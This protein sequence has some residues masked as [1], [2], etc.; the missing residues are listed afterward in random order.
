M[1]EVNIR[2]K[3]TTTYVNPSPNDRPAMTGEVVRLAIVRAGVSRGLVDIRE[4]VRPKTQAVEWGAWDFEKKYTQAVRGELQPHVR[5]AM[6]KGWEASFAFEVDD[7]LPPEQ[8]QQVLKEAGM[9]Y[10]VGALTPRYGKFEV[11][12]FRVV[13]E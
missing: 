8:L 7:Q 1:Y 10:G 12:D 5:P 4:M 13:S 6:K 2:L 11:E 9:V 3:G